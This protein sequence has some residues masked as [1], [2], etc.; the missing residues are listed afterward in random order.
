MIIHNQEFD[1]NPLNANDVERME[2]AQRQLERWNEAEN[3]RVQREH[4]GMAEQIRGQCR[5]MMRYLD[6]VLGAGAS[7]RLGLDGTDMN[8]CTAVF[9]ELADA[10]DAEFSGAK[11]KVTQPLNRAQRR[12]G[13][14]KHHKPP[15]S[16]PQP[17][18]AQMVERVDKAA[19]RK[20]LLA[21]LAAL[22]DE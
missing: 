15:V 6:A 22:D 21:Q 7:A 19:R 13:K 8:A 20:A 1:F 14:K 4:C 12:A 17:P 5:L 10:I 3:A 18:A 9:G 11:G 2:Q 16:Y